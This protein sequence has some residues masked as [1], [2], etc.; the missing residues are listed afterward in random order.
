MRS[1]LNLNFI[2]RL[3]ERPLFFEGWSWY[4]FNN[5]GLALETNLKFYASVAKGLKLKVRKVLA[6]DSYVRRSYRGKTGSGDGGGGAFCPTLS[7]V[8]RVKIY[9]K[10]IFLDNSFHEDC[11][12]NII[13]FRLLDR[14]IN[15]EK[16]NQLKKVSKEL[17]PLAWNSKRWWNFVCQRM[18]KNHENQFLLSNAFNV[19][20]ME[21]LYGFPH[22]PF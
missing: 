10:K 17:M 11:R 12:D 13:Q 9:L 2:R 22:L 20:N 5:L 7:I 14:R 21:M 18:R 15:F 16:R 6:A 3:P 1:Y 4:K 8:N 19:Y